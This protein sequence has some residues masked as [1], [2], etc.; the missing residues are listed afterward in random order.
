MISH[1]SFDLISLII[2]NV[3]HLSMCL[4][5]ICMSSLEKC[6]FRSCAHFLVVFFFLIELYE[7][8]VYFGN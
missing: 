2:S 3:E 1:C 5:A 7:L 8:F 4:L 6:L